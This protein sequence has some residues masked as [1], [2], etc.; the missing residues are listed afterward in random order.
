MKKFIQKHLVSYTI[1]AGFSCVAS[2]SSYGQITVDVSS[3]VNIESHLERLTCYDKQAANSKA[4]PVLEGTAVLEVTSVKPTTAVEAIAQPV[5]QSATVLQ[6]TVQ[7]TSTGVVTEENFG[8]AASRKEQEKKEVVEL[9][10]TI[11]ALKERVPGRF[12]ITLENGQIW[13]QKA[14]ERYRLKVGD[15]V[16]IYPSGWG[17]SFRL[18][19]IDKSG[20]IQVERLK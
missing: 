17:S 7:S 2:V 10:S 4:E 13:S 14:A 9:F 18:T 5:V 12:R 15:E 11:S 20:F 19:V 6:A 1:L 3:C 8:L 16:R